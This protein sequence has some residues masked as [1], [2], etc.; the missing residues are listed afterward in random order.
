MNT[1]SK[2]L[3]TG[4]NGMLGSS[5][6]NA[7]PLADKLNGKQDLDLTNT[8][9]TNDWFM[10]KYYDVIIH[11]A[12]F[13]DLKIARKNK[14]ATYSLHFDVNKIFL[15]RCKKLIYISTVPVWLKGLYLNDYY[16][17]SKK[18]GEEVVLSKK[19][20]AILRTNIVGSGG[21]VKWAT[22]E[23][24][25]GKK[26]NG[27]TNSWFNPIHVNQASARI[28]K[29][30]ENN[31]TG[32]LEA[33]GNTVVSKYDFLKQVAIKKKLNEN[34]ITGKN[35]DIEQDLTWN[36]KNNEFSYKECMELI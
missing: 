15:S 9:E 35:L 7:L 36:V 5:L 10:D 21:L 20:S 4:G 26:I 29:I 1:N 24:S 32:I 14:A 6:S 19:T 27:F 33:F 11:C 3:I 13:T 18:N 30:I 8:Q 2:I 25:D 28:K 12:A 22:K 16:F 31:E 23:L 17:D 34:L